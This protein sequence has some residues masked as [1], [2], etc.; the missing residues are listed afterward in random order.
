MACE[1]YFTSGTS[2]RSKGVLLSHE[3]VHAH[4]LH[5]IAEHRFTSA[6]VWLH[7]AP[8]FHLVDAFAMFAITAVCGKH[9]LL[10]HAFDAERTLETMQSKAGQIITTSLV[11]TLKWWFIGT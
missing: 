4:A 10:P 7:V 11:L 5:C 6:D 1:M 3:I 8:M 9:V 2:G